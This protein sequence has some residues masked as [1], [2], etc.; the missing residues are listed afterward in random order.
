MS[1]YLPQPYK[2][3]GGN[4]NVKINL[5]N[6][7]TKA[8]LIKATGVNTS[9]SAAKSN[10]AILKEEVDKIVVDKLKTV[11]VDLSKLSNAVRNEVVK[12]MYMIN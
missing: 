2:S 3:F 12:K 4:I 6:Y 7:A 9:K 10:L 5:S 11:P 1:Q 8:E